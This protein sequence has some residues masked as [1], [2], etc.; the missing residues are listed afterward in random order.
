MCSITHATCS[1]AC[2]CVCGGPSR[3]GGNGG[4]RGATS[5]YSAREPVAAGKT[6][7]GSA[8]GRRIKVTH[9]QARIIG[10]MKLA[11]EKIAAIARATGLSRPTIYAV[12]ESG[13]NSYGCAGC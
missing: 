4:G 1:F 2:V 5:E 7:G 10:Q 9:D 13:G 6:W 12:L 8:K 3:W 11:G